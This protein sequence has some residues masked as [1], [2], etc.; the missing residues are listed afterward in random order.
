VVRVVLWSQFHNLL[1]AC[2]I[3]LSTETEKESKREGGKEGKRHLQQS[4]VCHDTLYGKVQE[5]KEV[6]SA[7]FGFLLW[8]N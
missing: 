6:L 5:G 3:A 4:L 1:H 7:G 2:L 8:Q